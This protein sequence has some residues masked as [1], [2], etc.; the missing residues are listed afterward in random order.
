MKYANLYYFRGISRIG[1]IEQF[2]YELA[3]KYGANGK[4]IDLVIVY[5]EADKNQ[6]ARLKKHLRCIKYQ[7]GMTFECERAFFNFNTDIIDDV[8]ADEYVLVVHGDYNM[9]GRQSVPKHPK[10]D[11]YVGVSKVCSDAFTEITGIPCETC[12]NPLSIE[13]VDK[14]L[15]LVSA[16][17]LDDKVKG[18][19]RTQQMIRAMDE[20][21][22]THQRQYIWHIFSNPTVIKLESP[23]V[24]FMPTRLDIRPF[25]ADADFVVSL[26]D[27]FEGFNY[28]NNE[29]LMY[30]TPVVVTPCKVYKELGFDE[31]MAIFVDF[32]MENI[33]EVI[34]KMFEVLDNGG[35]SFDYKPPKDG[36]SKLLI[37]KK[38]TYLREKEQ[39]VLVKAIKPF[40]DIEAKVTRVVGEEWEVTAERADEL[41]GNN[42][43]HKTFAVRV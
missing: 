42:P 25:I 28:T 31:S 16:C 23:N 26:S 9:L 14:V 2:F 22:L 13:P 27:D 5:K 18:G 40:A 35:M 32:D 8:M 24:A 37:P 30:G 10:I 4:N 11:R 39:K 29:A 34:E 20:W 1:G 41:S 7:K 36:W 17:R 3:K 6:L 21:C 15:H 33:K 12:Y 19:V 38:S 43:M